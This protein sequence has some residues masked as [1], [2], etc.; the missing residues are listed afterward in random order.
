MGS[1][2]SFRSADPECSSTTIRIT[3]LRQDCSP[4]G[5]RWAWRNSIH[6]SST[7]T[8]NISRKSLDVNRKILIATAALCL[9]TTA[10]CYANS[11][12]NDFIL[13]DKMIVASNPAIRTIQ[14]LHYFSTPFWGQGS[15][16]GIYRPL[17]ML[18]FSLEYSIWQ[19]WSP[20]FH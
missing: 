3:P 14:P 11:L 4:Q 15:R 18:S 2:T 1:R 19:R 17:V 12:R 9:A 5:R 10:I 16:E 6:G 13:D 7:R 8:P 20:G